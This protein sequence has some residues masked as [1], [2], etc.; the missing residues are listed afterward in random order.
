MA[1]FAAADKQQTGFVTPADL[2]KI[3]SPPPQPRSPGVT[4]QTTE[5][6]PGLDRLKDLQMLLDGE[7]GSLSQGPSI[8]DEAPDFELPLQGKTETVKLSELRGRPVVLV[9]GSFT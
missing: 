5:Y 4:P 2:A 9:F 6:R 1:F 7:F 3:L 8:D